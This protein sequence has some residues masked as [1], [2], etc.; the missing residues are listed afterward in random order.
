M[1]HFERL[2]LGMVIALSMASAAQAQIPGGALNYMLQ[3]PRVAKYYKHKHAFDHLFLDAGAGPNILG[4][5][6][7]KLGA[8]GAL[9]VGDWI[10]PE[11]G[12][13]VGVDA[14]MMRIGSDKLKYASLSLDYMLNITAIATP[15]N[16]YRQHSAELYGIA[17]ADYS[18][19]RNEGRNANGYGVHIGA[20]GQF[21]ISPF[22]YFYVEPRFGIMQDDVSQ[23]ATW[24][25]FRP[26]GNILLGF[27]YRLPDATQATRTGAGQR[28]P[29]GFADG[30]FIT[31]MAGPAFLANGHPSTW[32]DHVGMSAFMGIG[33]WLSASN[34]VRLGLQATTFRQPGGNRLKAVGARADYLLNLN[35]LFGGANPRR[36]FWTNLVLGG[37]YNW[38]TDRT[39]NARHTWGAGGGLQA[40]LRLSRCLDFV[41]EP[42]VD[43][44]NK[45]WAPAADSYKSFDA[46]ASL[47]AGLVY[48][49]RETPS[50]AAHTKE[51]AGAMHRGTIGLSGGLAVPLDNY[52]N[53][54]SYMPV[55]RLSYTHWS[56]PLSGWRYSLQ[57]MIS[58]Q[59]GHSRY[60]LTTAG[61]DW[62][63]DLTALSYG[64]DNSRALTVRTVA[65]ISL[66][67]EHSRSL[68]HIASD[69]HAGV[70][71]A[72][73]L[74]TV[75]SLT[76][77]PQLA[78]EF[79]K[80]YEGSRS[81][82]LQP[83]AQIGLE[84]NMQRN[85]ANS[86]LKES[87][88]RPNF[89]TASIGT[90]LYTGNFNMAPSNGRRLTFLSDA[91]FGH[92]FNH[93]SGIQATIGN[94]VVQ[95]TGKNGNENL[96][97]VRA[98]YMI[99]M[100]SAITGEPTEDHLFHL[101]GLAGATLGIGSQRNHDT[102]VA[103]GL[104]AAMQ[105]GLRVSKSVEL[106]V[107]PS[108]TIFTN[109]I[110]TV[111]NRHA[112]EGEMR[113]SIGTKYHF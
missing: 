27:G 96:T 109:K 46:S 59:I 56:T 4:S 67:A 49:Y 101:T 30:L 79:S 1:K 60:A 75:V 70:Q 84:F 20:R 82:R 61:A 113:L 23:N 103:P 12:V 51:R 81:R 65:G 71:A 112:A 28:E 85:H 17:G 66:G 47:M 76:I 62:L 99:N 24:H 86:D 58:R 45:R 18:F 73:R 29:A 95:R 104:H 11:H 31:A 44:L 50:K 19:S 93:V 83:Q 15:G 98:D 14:G 22:T 3:R 102:R 90:G 7:M 13:R 64:C 55:A 78:Y 25:G 36:V 6:D 54:R 91:G 110:E 106:Y 94:T 21:A 37:S 48:T 33:K 53:W 34:G 42:R 41:L 97:V 26:T 32:D 40:N 89:V 100:K 105:A 63:T 68:T 87:P 72:F 80:H 108:A 92:W 9:R 77:E 43:F 38:S 16:N 111:G 8:T 74:S 52:S 5:G 69:M 10:S 2:A 107:E 88:E 39:H 57:G 35:N